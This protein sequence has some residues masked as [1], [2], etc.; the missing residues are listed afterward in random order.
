LNY[1]VYYKLDPAQAEASR[2][3]VQAIFDA[4][5]RRLGIRGRWMRRRDDAATF[6]EVY[7]GIGDAAAFE[8]LLDQ[9]GA[10]LGVP[11]KVERFISA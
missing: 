1:Y 5:E 8:A 10:R 7:E 11:R 4:I 2:A 3:K 6:M 9:E